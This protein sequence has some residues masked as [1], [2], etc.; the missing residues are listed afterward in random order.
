[1]AE[2]VFVSPKKKG[3]IA[4]L[5]DAVKTSPR[6]WQNIGIVKTWLL[7]QIIVAA[8]LVGIPPQRL[9]AWYRRE[10]GRTKE[11]V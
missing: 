8:Y 6:R 3:K 2:D 7:N 10:K 1:M 9:A 11:R 4:I 5:P